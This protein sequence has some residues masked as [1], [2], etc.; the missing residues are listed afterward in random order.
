MF[1]QD[2]TLIGDVDCSGEVNS[3]DASLILQFVTN[4]ID[5]LPCE[6]NMTGL[7][8][9]QLQEMIDMMEETSGNGIDLMFPEG[10]SED[11]ITE[12][13]YW[14]DG[15]IVPEGKNLYITNIFGL[16][17]V[18]INDNTI[19]SGNFNGG[20]DE[21]ND[22]WRSNTSLGVPLILKAGDVLTTNNDRF[23]ING[24]LVDNTN[25]IEPIT[26]QPF[27][28]ENLNY[29]VPV[30]KKLL[31]TNVYIY[32]PN[33]T[34]FIDDKMIASWPMN[35]QNSSWL[36]SEYDVVVLNHPLLVNEGEIVHFT[37]GDGATFNGYLVDEDYFSSAGS[38][39]NSNVSDGTM[40]V[41]VFGDT[42][43]L[44]G[45]SIIVPGISYENTPDYIFGSVTDINGNTYQTVQIGSQEW[46]T[47]DLRATSFSNGDPI[48]L[49]TDVSLCYDP[50]Y[51]DPQEDGSHIY[52]N[53]YVILDV[54]NVCPSGWHIPSQAEYEVL[55]D[56]FGDY[57]GAT[58]VGSGA[59]LKSNDPTGG[60]NGGFVWTDPLSVTNY[61]H[62]SFFPDGMMFCSSNTTYPGNVRSWTSSTTNGGT[63]TLDLTENSSNA[64]FGSHYGIPSDYLSPCR[65]VKD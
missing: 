9:D 23:S 65:C 27:L 50:A 7:T 15:Y 37:S 1:A 13:I 4:V 46:M 60:G 8:P 2:S 53:G 3:Q 34:L 25:L 59:A 16:G 14:N 12:Q 18:L 36:N 24:F 22:Q 5:E 6:A 64:G 29:Q 42:L 28:L 57:D 41:S 49:Q 35:N 54:R 20:L 58:W 55:L 33:D 19:L 21:I 26:K 32:S 45:E 56:V 48:A 61:S 63:T 40:S 62:L 17:N 10:Y 30:N 39:S 44:N 51:R 31:I 47:E 43:S 11:F 38:G 52:Y